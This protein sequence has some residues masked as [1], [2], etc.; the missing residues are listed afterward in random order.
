MVERSDISVRWDLSPR[1]IT[2]AA[3]STEVTIQDLHDTLRELECRPGNMIYPYL[4]STAG[5]EAVGGDVYVGLTATLQ[6]A[7]L[8][9]E[10][11]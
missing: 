3:P 5:G 8:N 6:N 4:I 2:V 9:F 1:L 11:R 7:Q 10:A